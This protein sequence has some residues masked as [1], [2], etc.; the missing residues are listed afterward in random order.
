MK[1][2]PGQFKAE[3]FDAQLRAGSIGARTKKDFVLEE[4]D[5]DDEPQV[6]IRS[7][8][9]GSHGGPEAC[10]KAAEFLG[11]A[12]VGKREDVE[13]GREAKEGAAQTTIAH[14]RE[15]IGQRR[16]AWQASHCERAMCG[17]TTVA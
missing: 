9:T 12:A 14:W 6:N 16:I 7:A 3:D 8:C 2:L 11:C 5:S 10:G 13:E 17:S 1:S 4:S 15:Q